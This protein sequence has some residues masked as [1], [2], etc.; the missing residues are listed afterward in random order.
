MPSFTEVAGPDQEGEAGARIAPR[1]RIDAPHTV[2]AE[3]APG[4]EPPDP[5][6]FGQ[7]MLEVVEEPSPEVLAAA[8]GHDPEIRRE[9]LQL[10]AAQLAGHLRERLRDVDRR[11]AQLNARVAQLESDLRA[12]RLWLAEREHEFQERETTLRRQIED[13]QAKATGHDLSADPEDD[14]DSRQQSLAERERQCQL[15]ENDLRER[16]FE[17]DRQAVALRHAQ[18]MWEQERQR[19]QAELTRQGQL[20]TQEFAAETAQRDE[21]LRET[22]SLL[23]E[24]ARQ[25]DRDRAALLADRQTWQEEQ[26]RQ[27]LALDERAKMAATELD[28]RRLRLDGRQ[29]WLERQKQGL[30]QVRSEILGLHRQSLEMRLVA[31][32]AWAQLSGRLSPAEVTQ[33]IAHLRLKLAEHY[34]IEEDNLCARRAELVELGEKIAAQHRELTQLREG[35]RGWTA[36]R[37]A[38]IEAQAQRLVERELELDREQERFRQA[39]HSWQAERRTYE[40]QIR[41]LASQLRQAPAAA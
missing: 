18:Q 19:Q 1:R 39:Q 8:L 35:V 26:T 10:Q 2:A 21:R 36:A 4:G 28:D 22:E 29:E 31:E 30:E 41:D 6:A 33:A 34:R 24:H 9:Q 13:L 17:F 32:Q 12:S 11:E 14:H 37:Q 20:L 15:K 16:K 38:E 3:P 5:V 40:Q 7:A 23:A 27:K 25:L